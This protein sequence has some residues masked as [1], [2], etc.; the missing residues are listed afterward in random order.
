M[1]PRDRIRAILDGQP[2]DRLPVDIWHTDEVL[3][4]LTHHF[5]VEDP[6]DL[7][8]AMGIDKM[9][10]LNVPYA[11]PLAPAKHPDEEVTHWGIR[12]APVHAGK[13]VYLEHAAHPLGGLDSITQ[14]ADYPWWPDPDLFDYDEALADAKRISKRFAILGPWVSFFE[15]Y[16]WMRGLEQSLADVLM[17]PDFVNA[18][19]DRIEA[20]Q[21][22][23]LRR[24]LSRA[25]PF[26]DAVFISD[27]MG[28]QESLLISLDTWDELLKPRL[29]R[30][31]DLIHEFGVRVFYHSDGA[32]A[33]LIPRLIGAGVDI[34]NPIQHVCRGMDMAGLKRSFGDQL[35]FH[36]AIDNQRVL[37][38]GSPDDVRRATREALRILGA[39]RQGYI[40][41]SCHNIQAGTPVESILAMVDTVQQEG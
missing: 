21:T 37:P 5:G 2:V 6:L 13:A 25:A 9:V 32:C 7:Y 39:E 36:G 10:W 23:M 38:F 27:D 33:P 24:Y 14:L 3:D 17:A 26:V 41:C 22:G 18:A 12:Q 34:L 15:I 28:T 35:V 1:N 16:C 40:C 31:C 4:D 11:G 19:L 30:W 20:A 29:K 8:E